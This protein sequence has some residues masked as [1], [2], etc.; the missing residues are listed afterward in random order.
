MRHIFRFAISFMVALGLSASSM[1]ATE[2]TM[3]TSLSANNFLA[4]NVKKFV[5]DAERLSGGNLKITLHTDGVLYK[6]AIHKRVLQEGQVDLAEMDFNQYGN[7]DPMYVL[8]NTPGLVNSLDEL[9][10]LWELQKPYFDKLFAERG[11]RI[12]YVGHWPGQGFYT[13]NPINIFADAKGQRLRISSVQTK[14]MGDMLGFNSTIL[15][16]AEVPQAFSTGLIDAM[17]TSAQTGV[18]TQAW[19]HVKHFAL[20]VVGSATSGVAV[21]EASF[22]KLDKQSQDALIEAGRIAY[23]SS[24]PSI[25]EANVNY[26][27]ELEANGMTAGNAT[28]AMM[29]ELAK[30]GESMVATWRENVSPEAIE[31]LDAF[32]AKTRK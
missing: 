13:R 26:M 28:E 23:E 8:I 19:D 7:E 18:D 16:S 4:L 17:F 1:A 6:R 20:A 15:P 27:K 14:Q 10:I 3:S 11:L 22:Q 21:N 5:A 30:V 2:L 9:R 29:E 24:F 25:E 32:Y 12:L 31:I